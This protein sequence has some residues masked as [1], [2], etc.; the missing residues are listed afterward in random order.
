MAEVK[1]RRVRNPRN[2]KADGVTEV[3]PNSIPGRPDNW[4]EKS[5]KKEE[6]TTEVIELS[7]SGKLCKKIYIHY[8]TKT[9]KARRLLRVEK[10]VKK[11]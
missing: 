7:P 10:D 11:I 1:K 6:K 5:E 2:L 9:G 3:K 4:N 8:R